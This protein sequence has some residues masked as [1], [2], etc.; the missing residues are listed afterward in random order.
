M[1]TPFVTG[2]VSATEISVLPAA[3]VKR[4]IDASW[5]AF[6]HTAEGRVYR[7]LHDTVDA[8]EKAER[9][10]RSGREKFAVSCNYAARMFVLQHVLSAPE[11]LVSWADV[12]DMSPRVVMAYG[13]AG[14]LRALRSG[15]VGGASLFGDVVAAICERTGTVN[16]LDG[17]AVVRLMQRSRLEY[18]EPINVPYIVAIDYAR[19]VAKV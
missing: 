7:L 15:R 5:W 11:S 1:S 18:S 4:V 12:A 8:E 19:D 3:F 17:S 2:P 14:K 10:H 9:A 16:R 6:C 13:L